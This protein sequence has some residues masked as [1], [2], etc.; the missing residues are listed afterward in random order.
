MATSIDARS[1]AAALP[2]RKRRGLVRFMR[3]KAAVF[4][5][6][7]V[8]LIVVMALFAPWLTQ[9]DPVQ[10]SFMTVR[11]APSAA[12]WFGTDE[13]GRDVLS[14]LLYGARASLLAGVVS[15][16]IAV[17]LG[18]P[19]GLLAGY[20]GKLVDGVISRIADALL[21]IPFLILA[22]AL[23]AFLG[24]SLT[25]A[26]AAIGISAMPRFIRLTRGQAISVKAEEYVEGARAIGLDHAR[27]ILRYILP[28][29]LPPIIV[30]ASLTV[31]SA[32]IAEA[33]LSFL[34]LGQLPPAPSWGSMLNTAKDFVS[35]APWM[36]IFPGIAIF[37]AVLG[38][39]L[40]GD[41]LRDALDPRE[42]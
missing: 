24:P 23:S 11:Q 10:A 41:G 16:G 13:L 17:V 1:A 31:A 19:L 20:F 22:I 15:V 33:S 4:G 37:L 40:L 25:N 38:F 42:S 27:I 39:N 12:H 36:S 32:I 34:G 14:R 8:A 7:L 21:S 3:N 6:I 29:V 26:M 28:N 18:V 2:R 5:A 30:Q 35:Q 9:Y